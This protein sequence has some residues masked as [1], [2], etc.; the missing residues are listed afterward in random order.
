MILAAACYL[1]A[2]LMAGLLTAFH[3]VS[4]LHQ[5]GLLEEEK[6]GWVVKQALAQGRRFQVTVSSLYLVA[7]VLGVLSCG[8]LLAATWDTALD[9]RFHAVFAM[10][11]VLAWTLGAML[12]KMMAAGTAMGF[13]RSAGALVWPITQ[14]LRPLASLLLMVMDKLD[15]TLWAAEAQPLLSSG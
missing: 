6:L 14:L 11:V 5:N 15:D 12:F 3:R 2:M 10:L 9:L 7:T 8:R 1:A 13:L 4:T